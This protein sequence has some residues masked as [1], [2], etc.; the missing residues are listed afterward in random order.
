MTPR[1]LEAVDDAVVDAVFVEG[2]NPAT[3]ITQSGNLHFG[4]LR[5]LNEVPH[6][7]AVNRIGDV[8]ER[9]ALGEIILNRGSPLPGWL[10]EGSA[11]SGELVR[12]NPVG[13]VCRS[14]KQLTRLRA[15]PFGDQ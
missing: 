13:S 14:G 9:S 11:S 7:A 2:F 8:I 12:A 5:A 4:H 1:A 10:G 15:E 3:Q 6:E